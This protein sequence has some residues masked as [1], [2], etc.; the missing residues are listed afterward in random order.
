MKNSTRIIAMVGIA[1]VIAIGAMTGTAANA[2]I[3]PTVGLGT[4]ASSSVLAGTPAISST[5]L[6]TI[7]LA[8]ADLDAQN[9]GDPSGPL[10]MLGVALTA[11]GALLLRGRPIRHL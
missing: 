6:T 1:F 5:G 4:A 9:R 2:A 8:A 10:T 11:I 3:V 7:D